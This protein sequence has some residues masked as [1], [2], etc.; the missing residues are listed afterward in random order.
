MIRFSSLPC[1]HCNTT[2][3]I[4]ITEEEWNA[5]RNGAY[6]QDALSRFSPAIRERFLTG[7]CQESWNEIFGEDE[8]YE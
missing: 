6:I 8:E 3:T 2:E 1:P 7:I 4:E 5:L